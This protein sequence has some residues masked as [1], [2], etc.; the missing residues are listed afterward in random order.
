MFGFYSYLAYLL[1]LRSLALSYSSTAC[2]SLPSTKIKR[3]DYI[4]MNTN[5]FF[6]QYQLP[7][8]DLVH[9]PLNN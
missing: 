7:H 8:N 4:L 9:C 3:K 2:S 1:F 6:L 5:H